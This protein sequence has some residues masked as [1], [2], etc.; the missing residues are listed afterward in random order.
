MAAQTSLVKLSGSQNT[1]KRQDIWRNL[2]E[3]DGVEGKEESVNQVKSEMHYI[4]I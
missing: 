2:G 1:I 3:V 4:H